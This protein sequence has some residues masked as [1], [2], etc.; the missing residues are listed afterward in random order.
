MGFSRSRSIRGYKHAIILV[1]QIRNRKQEP[2]ETPATAWPNANSPVRITPSSSDRLGGTNRTVTQTVSKV[3]PSNKPQNWSLTSVSD[4]P[5][6]SMMQ[7]SALQNLH[8][9]MYFSRQGSHVQPQPMQAR[10]RR[11]VCGVRRG[12]SVLVV[13]DGTVLG[14][15]ALL[16]VDGWNYR[17]PLMIWLRML[18]TPK[19]HPQ[20]SS[21]RPPGSARRRVWC[22]PLLLLQEQEWL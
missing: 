5:S 19:I 8:L 4:D 6:L 7:Y 14:C 16:A 18:F 11:L 15:P 1:Q 20:T 22:I 10:W 21:S 12:W 13:L 9:R 2:Q 17:S 3:R